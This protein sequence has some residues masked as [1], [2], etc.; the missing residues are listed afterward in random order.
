MNILIICIIE[1]KISIQAFIYL[2]F[3]IAEMLIPIPN[4]RSCNNVIRFIMKGDSV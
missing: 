1:E 4:N 3:T 2:Y